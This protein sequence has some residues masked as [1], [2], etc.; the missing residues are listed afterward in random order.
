MEFLD[1]SHVEISSEFIPMFFMGKRV[2]Q[3]KADISRE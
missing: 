2:F 3:I 1:Y